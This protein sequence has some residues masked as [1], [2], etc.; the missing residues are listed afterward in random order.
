A[1][2]RGWVVRAI[3][4]SCRVA[5]RGVDSWPLRRLHRFRIMV[6]LLTASVLGLFEDRLWEAGRLE[7]IDGRDFRDWLKSHGASDEAIDCS[8]VK[9][10]YDAVVAYER[11]DAARPR[12][13]AGVT[14]HAL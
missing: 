2:T 14:I 4:A 3:K 7:A 13:S 8:L 1:V 5:R 12:I 6:S 10:W 11:G 9:S